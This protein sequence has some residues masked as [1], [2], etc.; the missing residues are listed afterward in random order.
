MADPRRAAGP[1]WSE[2]T[3][4]LL[5]AALATVAGLI[6]YLQ[7]TAPSV[8]EA[9]NAE[10]QSV[11]I[12]GG[13]PHPTGYPT[14]VLVGRLFAHLPFSDP[15]FRINVMS[16]ML[17]ALALG[18][19][20]VLLSTL[21]LSRRGA[22]AGALLYGLSYTL[23]DS[24][25][26]A[27]T[28]TLS[29]CL[30]VLGL[31]RTIVALRQARPRDLVLAGLLLGLMI[32]GHMSFLL[33][34]AALGLALVARVVVARQRPIAGLALLA[35]GFL[36]GLTPFLYTLWAD[37]RSYS[38]NY[39]RLLD[40]CINPLRDHNP[41]IDTSWHRMKWLLFGRNELHTPPIRLDPVLFVKRLG[42]SAIE[43]FLFELGPLA[44]PFLIAGLWRRW[45]VDRRIALA[46]AAAGAAALVVPGL[47]NTG[48]M[49]GVFL[50]PFTLLAAI[51]T[52]DG[53][54]WGL[55]GIATRGRGG[56]I[57]GAILA[58]AAPLLIA[59]PAHLL[60]VHA[61]DHPLGPKHNIQAPQH[62]SRQLRGVVPSMHGYWGPRRFG[63]RAM[64][65]IPPDALVSADWGPMTVLCYLQWVEHRRPD[66]T[67]LPP[68]PVIL[69]LWQRTHE[70]SSHPFV[71]IDRSPQTAPYLA[72]V[73]SL[74][75]PWD[76]WL[77]VVRRPLTGLAT[78]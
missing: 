17:A 49:L 29:V 77:F 18:L 68:K 15:A 36:L 71:F 45:R 25:L 56:A 24:A 37:G 62:D 73:D 41:P 22:F 60:R 13:I 2:R 48:F 50:I 78:R 31:W 55:D 46:L 33:P 66:L 65:A 61:Y 57:A 47:V 70:P 64:E 63:E 74:A 51:F 30:G 10:L 39:L 69:A 52:A 40:T 8:V 19:M 76:Q 20:V 38:V 7:G 12:L 3:R 34:V 67:I 6:L 42:S 32:T 59:L 1:A 26:R 4:L 14:F 72:G 5:T 53:L 54:A 16:G 35:G 21:G 44:G 9:D 23:W 27:G 58:V 11:A 75:L 28:Y 43:L